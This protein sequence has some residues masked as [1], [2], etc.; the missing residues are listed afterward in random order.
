MAGMMDR[1][2]PSL[3]PGHR[4]ALEMR[5]ARIE[6]H[7]QQVAD[8][9]APGTELTLEIGCGHGHYLT[10]FAQAHPEEAC[11]GVDLVTRRIEKARAKCEKR[12]LGNVHFLKAD[13]WESVE[14]L[15]A[16]MSLKRIFILYPDPWPK[17]RHE[18][19]RLLQHSLL[20][21]LASRA[22]AGAH[23]HFRTDHVGLSDWAFEQLESHPLWEVDAEAVWPFESGSFFQDLLGTYR[24]VTAVRCSGPGGA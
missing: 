21:L 5:R 15:P 10:A 8:W 13:A 22:A 17:N 1:E 3:S 9:F 19:N 18:K 23:L 16:T 2:A 14:A 6:Q 4:R 7:Q 20:D 11:L 12:Q 24:S